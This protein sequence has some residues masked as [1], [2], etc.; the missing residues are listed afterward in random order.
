MIFMLKKGCFDLRKGLLVNLGFLPLTWWSLFGDPPL[1]LGSEDFRDFFMGWGGG[2]GGAVNPAI[3]PG[4]LIIEAWRLSGVRSNIPIG[5]LVGSWF[6]LAK[7]AAKMPPL[8]PPRFAW[9]EPDKPE[10]KWCYERRYVFSHFLL[11]Q[12]M[13]ILGLEIKDILTLM[14]V[15]MLWFLIDWGR[16][17]NRW[18]IQNAFR[19]N[20]LIGTFC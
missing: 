12:E 20:H 19:F 15:W 3:N 11:K 4:F 1:G 5:T 10:G 2:K 6:I 7:W 8:P 17:L 9:A 18:S 16:M 13:S 14:C